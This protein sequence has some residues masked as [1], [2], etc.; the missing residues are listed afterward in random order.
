MALC[1]GFD[2]IRVMLT[3][4]IPQC[5][6]EKKILQV[7]QHAES[8]Q[9]LEN[10]ASY[11]RMREYRS[12]CENE[13]L[14]IVSLLLESALYDATSVKELS[15]RAHSVALS[16]QSGIIVPDNMHQRLQRAGF[17]TVGSVR[18]YKAVIKEVRQKLMTSGKY[19]YWVGAEIE[20]VMHYHEAMM[21]VR[22]STLPCDYMHLTNLANILPAPTADVVFDNLMYSSIS[23]GINYDGQKKL[24]SIE[25]PFFALVDTVVMIGGSPGTRYSSG[26]P[27]N[28]P[29][30]RVA[31]IDPRDVEFEC[32]HYDVDYSEDVLLSALSELDNV[33]SIFLS[34]DIRSD[35]L[36]VREFGC[37]MKI[38]R[39]HAVFLHTKGVKLKRHDGNFYSV[40][41][42]EQNGQILAI[43]EIT[44]GQVFY[45]FYNE[46]KTNSIGVDR[47][48]E[49]I[50]YGKDPSEWNDRVNEDWCVIN[51]AILDSI[52]LMSMYT[53]FILVKVRAI[54]GHSFTLPIAGHL[55][56]EPYL[57]KG[58]SEARV[59]LSNW[60]QFSSK[61]GRKI[62]TILSSD[63]LF[64][65]SKIDDLR[66]SGYD[67]DR[68]I[69]GFWS[70]LAVRSEQYSIPE[71]VF[72]FS[73]S[74]A[75]ND[76]SVISDA[77]SSG[78][79]V[80][81]P[82][83][84]LWRKGKT[85]STWVGNRE[86]LD[87]GVTLLDEI[88][89]DSYMVP[90]S[91]FCSSENILSAYSEMTLSNVLWNARVSGLQE[92][93]HLSTQLVKMM[94]IAFKATFLNADRIYSIRTEVLKDRKKDYEQFMK[95]RFG[96]D[97]VID[98]IGTS[99]DF[100]FHR[101]RMSVSGHLIYILI[102]SI[103]GIP[104]G[105]RRYI[106]E[107]RRNLEGEK[108]YEFCENTI[109]HLLLED[110]VALDCI[111]P[112]MREFYPSITVQLFLDLQLILNSLRQELLKMADQ[113]RDYLGFETEQAS[114]CV[115]IT[116]GP[117]LIFTVDDYFHEFNS[118]EFLIYVPSWTSAIRILPPATAL[119][120]NFNE[121]SSSIRIDSIR[122][123]FSK[124]TTIMALDIGLLPFYRTGSEFY[125]NVDQLSIAIID[126]FREVSGLSRLY[127]TLQRSAEDNDDRA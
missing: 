37:S 19:K 56:V 76:K 29:S 93:T 98:V 127:I 27:F 73:L 97:S 105:I 4:L 102:A 22:S 113:Y 70:M 65:N 6:S 36:T 34:I 94:S 84:P 18:D 116:E 62:T 44:N 66:E 71:S 83:V 95:S 11:L 3:T 46:V 26:L 67:M 58:S 47:F 75:S 112:L 107:K 28:F 49:R 99:G 90:L 31:V 103:I 45:T 122:P 61:L 12:P 81:S 40:K 106:L 50:M 78:G 64:M 25:F 88:M 119:L 16:H 63:I 111:I 24:W 41:D 79:L 23:S 17:N 43:K 60:D 39:R 87:H 69:S 57:K 33:R 68:L 72:L 32:N 2:R 51:Q 123:A 5:V 52:S 86:Y 126:F 7:R 89:Y 38:S 115:A 118:G 55:L 82:Y 1:T 120:S 117:R 109:W 20:S 100:F 101:R 74:N 85:V 96:I 30:S 21:R 114:S 48:C 53:V 14:V 91:Y 110:L 92:D 125:A 8:Y 108:G 54:E 9:N 59:L 35:V 15:F 42:V 104:Y 80:S 121:H 77:I 13:E 10:Y 124:V